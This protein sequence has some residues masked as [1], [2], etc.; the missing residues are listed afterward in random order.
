MK[1]EN[2]A[3]EGCANQ[4]IYLTAK[5]KAFQIRSPEPEMIWMFLHISG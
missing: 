4:D 5:T 3:K 1:D 2:F